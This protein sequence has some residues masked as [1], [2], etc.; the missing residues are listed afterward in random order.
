MIFPTTLRRLVIALNGM[1]GPE[2]FQAGSALMKPGMIVM[3]D[4]ADEVIECTTTGIPIGV[5][6][7]DADH[8]LM[9]VYALG[10]RIPIWMLGCGIDIY[11]RTVDDAAA[12]VLRGTIFDTC[13]ATTLKGCAKMKDAYVALTSNA[14]DAVGRGFMPFFWIGRSLGDGAL[15]TAVVRY[16]PV[17]L[18][19]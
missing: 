1:D 18:C 2:Y 13:E 19:F 8:D 5:V 7:C 4:D 3:E 9:T 17:K 10:E 14:T 6:G 16:V 15:T 11:I 12:T